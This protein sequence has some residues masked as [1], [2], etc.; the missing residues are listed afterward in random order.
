[1]D[2]LYRVV[3]S[4]LDWFLLTCVITDKVVIFRLRLLPASV[5]HLYVGLMRTVSVSFVSLSKGRGHGY[6]S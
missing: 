6:C 4:C 2:I 1:M 3:H 5:G